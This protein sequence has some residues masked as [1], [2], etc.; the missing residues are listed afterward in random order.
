MENTKKAVLV[1][2]DG[3]TIHGKG[4]GTESTRSGELVFNTSMTGYGEALT[5]P[6]YAGQ[7]LIMSYPLIGN[8]GFNKEWME[9]EKVQVEGFCI[10]EAEIS[11]HHVKN[12]TN[13]D[14]YLEKEG[15]GGICEID[16]RALVRKIRTGGV[17][18][19][20]L[21]V[22]EKQKPN[23]EELL[24][25]AKK[26]EY[27][28]QNYVQKVSENGIEEYGKGKKKVALIDYGVKGNIIQELN[29][30]DIAVT[31]FPYNAKADKIKSISPDGILLANGPGDP[32][33]LKNEINEIKKLMDLPLMGICLGH[34]LLA[35]AAGAKCYKLKFGHRGANHPVLDK[36]L[37]QVFITTQNHGFAI[38]EKSLPKEWEIT[39]VNLND[40]TCEGIQHKSLP[41]FSVQYHPEAHP[42][43]RDSRY[44]FDKFAKN[45]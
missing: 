41:I 39:H 33:M 40:K 15:V 25:I 14:K 21:Q 19:C 9:S 30:R 17:M 29:K 22:Y 34:Q 13:L 36:K 31:R 7:I 2:S 20:A 32:A 16:T 8:Y 10:R 1:L 45:L 6:S 27:S 4:I 5:D 24:S 28:S 11:P 23:I 38:D 43:P 26:T 42:G 37:Q 12:N 3:T 44:L 35:Y 18:P